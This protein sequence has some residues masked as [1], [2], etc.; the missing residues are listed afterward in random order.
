MM[1]A[2]RLLWRNK[3]VMSTCEKMPSPAV[4]DLLLL[5]FRPL[6]SWPTPC[7]AIAAQQHCATLACSR[8]G[9]RVGFLPQPGRQRDTRIDCPAFAASEPGTEKTL[10]FFLT[11]R[12]IRKRRSAAIAICPRVSHTTGQTAESRST[13]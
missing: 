4:L 11:G 9:I 3:L 10:G 5:R 8:V 12:R 2:I 13:S 1:S 6:I 7:R